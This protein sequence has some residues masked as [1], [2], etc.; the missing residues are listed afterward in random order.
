MCDRTAEKFVFVS[1]R[2]ICFSQAD[3][4]ENETSNISASLDQI[5]LHRNSFREEATAE[6]L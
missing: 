4:N 3:A 6:I 2:F 5:K 1:I